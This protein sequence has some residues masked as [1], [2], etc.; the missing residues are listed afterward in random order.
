MI[1][2]KTNPERKYISSD[3]HNFLVEI[4]ENKILAKYAFKLFT[5]SA[6]E[7]KKSLGI[8]NFYIGNV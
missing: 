1:S 4:G 2:S 5:R 3:F 8:V 7:L 6:V